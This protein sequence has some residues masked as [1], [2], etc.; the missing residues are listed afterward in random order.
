VSQIRFVLAS[1]LALALA[2]GLS[3]TAASAQGKPQKS[4][5]NE[6]KFVSYDEAASTVTVT[7][8]KKGKGNRNLIKKYKKEVKNGKDVTFNV[9][10]TG[11]ILKRTSVAI[12]GVKGE[13]TDL[14]PG[15][16]LQVYWIEDPKKPGELFARKIDVVLSEEELNARYEVVD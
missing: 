10:P 1:A 12:N 15:K 13:M 11:S 5:N 8:T 14:Q 7:I 16:S 6:A 4:V 9:I 3:A 2:A